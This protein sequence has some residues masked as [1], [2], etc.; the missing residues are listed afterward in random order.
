MDA[1]RP[2]RVLVRAHDAEVLAVAV[3][4]EHLAELAGVDQLLQLPDA[5][6]VEQQMARHQH[7]VALGRERDE[8]VHLGGAHR[9]RLLDEHVLAR[10]ERLLRERVVRRH[11]RRDHDGVERPVGEQ[12]VEVAS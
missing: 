4:A 9:R 10:L 2:E 8:L 6:V 3:D 11:R 1:E 5:G 7:E 12:L